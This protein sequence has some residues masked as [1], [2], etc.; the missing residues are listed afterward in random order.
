MRAA[1]A[2]LFFASHPID[3]VMNRFNVRHPED[4]A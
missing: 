4:K 3:L 2:A 1:D